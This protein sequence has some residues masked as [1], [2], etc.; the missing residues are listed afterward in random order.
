MSENIFPRKEVQPLKKNEVIEF[1]ITDWFIPESDKNRDKGEEPELYSILVYGTD[2]NSITYCV[3]IVGFEPF[4][5][6]KP[7][8]SWDKYSDAEFEDEVQK[9]QSSLL[10]NKYECIWTDRNTGSVSKYNKF[11]ITPALRNHFKGLSVEKKKN[12]W[13]FTNNTIFRYIKVTTR[14]LTLYNSLKYYFMSFKKNE[15][16]LFESN[17]DPFLRYIHIQNIKPCDWIQIKKYKII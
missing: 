6:I 4:F 2:D 1:Q 13:G 10:N 9:L 15:Y 11:I 16:K 7:D 3:K 17:I 8:E 14:S 5:Y 12:F